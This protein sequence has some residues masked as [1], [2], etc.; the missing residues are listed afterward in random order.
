MIRAVQ[1]GEYDTDHLALMMSQTGGGCRAS[2]YIA[3]L[4][5]ALKQ[6]GLSH[7][8]VISFN[9]VGMEKNP[10]FS[11]SASLIIKAVKALL[12]GDLITE[13]LY[14]VRPYEVVPGSADALYE[15]CNERML[16]EVESAGFTHFRKLVRSIIKEFEEFEI[17]E[18]LEKP[19][20][21]V[22]GEIL[23]KYH[24]GANNDIVG[25][26][27]REGGEA[28]V[29]GM[30]DFFLY[31]FYNK[32]FNY[33]KLAGSFK[34][35]AFNMTALK[36]AEKVRDIVRGELKGSKRFHVPERIEEVAAKAENILSMGSQC[37]E[38]WLLTGEMVELMDRGIENIVCLQPFAC[39]PNHVTGKGMIKPMRKYNEWSNICAIDF[40]PG[41]SE[42][43]QLNRIKLMMATAFKNMEKKKALEAEKKTG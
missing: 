10:G 38:G 42:V 26:I 1:S 4:R 5:Y 17:D 11:I 34:D 2:N 37:G 28:V 8:P 15:K 14:R 39:L 32:K 13:L 30:L 31:G 29:P 40:D 16:K 36:A 7:I 27:E 33:E 6:M 20:V 22:V 18:T 3:L 25:T 21:G 24:P 12:F 23:V 9:L 43:N 35:M 41:A 19:K